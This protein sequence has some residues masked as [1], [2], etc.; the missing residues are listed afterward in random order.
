MVEKVINPQTLLFKDAQT[1]IE[2]G[3][4]FVVTNQPVTI[5]SLMALIYLD[6]D[7]VSVYKEPTL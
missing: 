6:L 4:K 1:L 5:Q 2:E 3:W 7:A